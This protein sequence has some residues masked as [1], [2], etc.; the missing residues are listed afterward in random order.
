M[1]IFGDNEEKISDNDFV[2]NGKNVHRKFIL[3]ENYVQPFIYLSQVLLRV[4]WRL[5]NGGK[6]IQL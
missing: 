5:R 4:N 2:N 1:N 6:K 3:I